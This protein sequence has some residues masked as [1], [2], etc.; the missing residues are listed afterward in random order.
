MISSRYP[1]AGKIARQQPLIYENVNEDGTIIVLAADAGP[2]TSAWIT[3]E[4]GRTH[5]IAELPHAELVKLH[6]SLGAYIEQKEAQ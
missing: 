1:V 3:S 4:V 5:I 6:A 2:R